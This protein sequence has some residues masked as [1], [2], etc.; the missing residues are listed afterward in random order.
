MVI[1]DQ[2]EGAAFREHGGFVV[3][4]AVAEMEDQMVRNCAAMRDLG[5]VA[6]CDDVAILR[7]QAEKTVQRSLHMANRYGL[8][9]YAAGERGRQ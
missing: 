6:I 7:T 3:H 1:A 5:Q 2:T 9:G 8:R 4:R